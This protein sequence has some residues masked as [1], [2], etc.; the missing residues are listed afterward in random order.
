MTS[1]ILDGVNG[2]WQ[3]CINRS[4]R[5]TYTFDVASELFHVADPD[6]KQNVRIVPFVIGQDF[7]QRIGNGPCKWIGLASID[8]Y[9]LAFVFDQR[10]TRYYLISFVDN[11]QQIEVNIILH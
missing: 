10:N 2:T 4:T 8:R 9:I 11:G 5:H 7:K 1:R 3:F 6:K